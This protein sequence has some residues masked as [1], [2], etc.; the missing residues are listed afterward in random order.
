[1]WWYNVYRFVQSAEQAEGTVTELVVHRNNEGGQMYSPV[2]EFADHL[3]QRQEYRSK[4]S[5]RPSLY[6]VGDKVQI[7]YDRD[8]PDSASINHWLYLYL[9][10]LL[11]LSIGV[12]EIITV[13][14]MCIVGWFIVRRQSQRE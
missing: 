10:P 5:T 6:T 7:L 2:I 13:I 9:G 12:I 14:V 8:Q 3:G 1:V 4:Q 11:F